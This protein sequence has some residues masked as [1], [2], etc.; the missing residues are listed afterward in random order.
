MAVGSEATVRALQGPSTEVVNLNGRTLMPGFIEPHVHLPL[1]IQSQLAVPCGSEE[2]LLPVSTVISRLKAAV[3]TLPPG[4]WVVGTNFDPSRSSPLFQ[5]LTAND[6]DGVSTTIPVFV[7][8]ASTH[9]AYVNHKALEAANITSSTPNP[10]GGEIVK[11]P[12]G[13]PTG[14]LNEASAINL[15]GALIP[16]PPN[17]ATLIPATAANVIQQWASTGVTTSTDIALGLGSNVTSDIALYRALAAD[18]NGPLRFR[19]YLTGIMVNATNTPVQPNQ[20]DD[21]LKFI[22]VKF[23]GD[24]ST[25][26]FTAALTQPYI[27]N[28]TN[29][30]L[31]SFPNAA[32]MTETVR[33]FY[34]RGWQISIHANGDA[35]L[36]QALDTYQTLQTGNPNPAARRLR[37]EHFTVS[38]PDQ[39]ERVV[40]LGVLPSMTAGHPYFWG[41]V[42][43]QNILGAD[44]SMRIHPCASL[45]ARNIRFSFHSDSPV[46]QVN[47]L[48]Y[49]QTEA[50]RVPQLI[51]PAILG[52][53]QRITVDDALRAVTLDAAYAVFFEDKVGSLEVGKLADF[54]VLA[55][56]PRTVDPSTIASIKVLET[57]RDGKRVFQAP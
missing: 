4:Q 54:V 56:N 15:V 24:G 47:P 37:V 23:T 44:R 48:R 29:F 8:N 33:P 42:F 18:P 14:Q 20:G 9:I 5:D 26:G 6:L 19:C 57:Y 46:T 41:Q 53:E 27:N 52:P 11:G 55:N 28:A 45:K 36:D 21:R 38:R 49:V 50:T 7:L 10:P 1:T 43:F 40:S 17:A 32:N 34:D 35:A 16:P 13:Q 2:P 25:Q 51:P 22:G 39:L 30:G 31:L 3:G 12:D